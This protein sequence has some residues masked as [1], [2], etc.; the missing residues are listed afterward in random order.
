MSRD[1]PRKTHRAS[2]FFDIHTNEYSLSGSRRPCL[3]LPPPFITV[4]QCIPYDIVSALV[5]ICWNLSF[6][7]GRF[8]SVGADYSSTLLFHYLCLLYFCRI[9]PF[10]TV[11][12]FFSFFFFGPHSPI[13]LL[14]SLL[15]VSNSLSEY[16]GSFLS[17][18]IP[19][20]PPVAKHFQPVMLDFRPRYA[21][22]S[23]IW[24]V[25]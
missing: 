24:D 23:R 17:S 22:L 6:T 7:R 2:V 20:F 3:R 21:L 12:L 19:T 9:F 25:F 10:S 8:S 13:A 11:L 5:G 15:A 1:R 14:F 16:N 4:N 18:T